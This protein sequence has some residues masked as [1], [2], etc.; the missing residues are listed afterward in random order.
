[1][2]ARRR[3]T[4]LGWSLV[5][6]Q[7]FLFLAVIAGSLASGLGPPLPHSLP[8]GLF[9]VAAGSVGLVASAR[10]LGQA[11]TPIPLPNGTGLVA[12]GAYRWVRHPIYTFVVTVCLGVAV[13]A[14]TVFAYVAVFALAGFFEV[15]SR[16][17]EGFLIASYEGYAEYAARTGK[18]VPG[19]GK[20]RIG[21]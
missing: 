18:F 11:L 5:A 15:K 10:H 3:D 13:A 7:G 6:I 9:L 2:D 20:R 21:P 19:V 4:A 14:G 1:M 17:E 8:A 16:V 12:H